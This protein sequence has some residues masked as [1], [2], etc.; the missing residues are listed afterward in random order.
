MSRAPAELG[1]STDDRH[2][3]RARPMQPTDKP[4]LQ[5]GFTRL[6]PQ[7]RYHRFLSGVT[8]LSATQLRQLT[9]FDRTTQAAWVVFD[10]QAEPAKGVAVG[11]Y[12]LDEAD[13]GRAELALVVADEYQARGVGRRLLALLTACAVDRGVGAFTALTAEDNHRIRGWFASLGASFELDDH[14][15]VNMTLPLDDHRLMDRLLASGFDDAP[16]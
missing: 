2:P 10:A 11:R 5:E 9:E 13:P 6:S 7:S 15:E 12:V 3:L 4:Y 1:F 8:R 16:A 14:G